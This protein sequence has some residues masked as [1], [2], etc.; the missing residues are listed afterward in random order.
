M[1][2]HS[3]FGVEGLN[4]FQAAVRSF[5]LNFNESL[6]GFAWLANYPMAAG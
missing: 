5:Q 6:F 1:D 4:C 2:F 3:L